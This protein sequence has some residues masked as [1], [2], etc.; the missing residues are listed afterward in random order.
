V[1]PNIQLFKHFSE[2]SDTIYIL[3]SQT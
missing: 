1:F 3:L 2:L